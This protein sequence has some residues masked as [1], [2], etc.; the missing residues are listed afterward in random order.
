MKYVATTGIAVSLVGGVVAV[1]LAIGGAVVVGAE[2]AVVGGA[3]AA[4]LS[5]LAIAAISTGAGSG[6]AGLVSIL[7]YLENAEIFGL[8]I[9]GYRE[10]NGWFERISNDGN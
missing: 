2:A 9:F 4:A 7:T 5:G 3:E 8:G 6:V 1:G 10:R